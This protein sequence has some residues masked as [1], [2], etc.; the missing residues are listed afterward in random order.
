MILLGAVVSLGSWFI[1]GQRSRQSAAKVSTQ[2]MLL[3]RFFLFMGIFTVLMFIPQIIL[4]TRPSLF[5]VSMAWGYVV[6]H[7]FLYIAFAYTLRL[8]FSMIPRLADKQVFAIVAAAV[9]ATVITL[10]NAVTMIWGRLPAYDYINHVTL[11]N[12]H[13]FV[14]AGI[15][16]FAAV[17]VIPAAILIIMNGVR[18]PKLRIR[19]FLLGFGFILIMT[20][21]PL[22][23]TATTW[24]LYMVA[25]IVSAIGM[26][27]LAGGVL[28]RFEERFVPTS[29]VELRDTKPPLSM[30][31]NL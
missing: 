19:S 24:Q 7:V 27:V 8:T 9:A 31:S 10:V 16:L 29:P 18:N 15:A 26:F 5:P 6:G 23:D 30:R 14:G 12:A 21:G 13:P 2:V 20:A 17:S 22:H 11:F 3:Q 25:D 1:I 4:Y 28:Y